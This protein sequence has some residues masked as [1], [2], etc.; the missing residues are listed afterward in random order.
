MMKKQLFSSRRLTLVELVVVLTI[1]V[2]LGGIALG[3]APDLLT[4]THVAASVTNVTEITKSLYLY[5]TLNNGKMPSGFDSLVDDGG[6]DIYLALPGIT[7]Y[8]V[9]TPT[10]IATTL[11]G[12]P[13][14]TG[15]DVAT[16]LVD[17][18]LAVVYPMDNTVVPDPLGTGDGNATF[19]VDYS[20][21][22]AV[23]DT[24]PLAVIDSTNIA[25]VF[26]RDTTGKVYVVLGIGSGCTLIGEASNGGLVEPPLHFGDTPTT[27]ANKSYT[28]YLAIYSIEND[29]G[30]A[31]VRYVGTCAPHE[32][33]LEANS[34]H[35]KEWYDAN[36][37]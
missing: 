36:A 37:D 7:E 6:T 29:D 1:L 20:T 10:D 32:S 25:R 28:R 31:V 5:S 8:T 18:G 16:A 17:Q 26:N 30:E 3:I 27:V 9:E 35:L 23:T 4:R 14:L 34:A 21:P 24:T 15:A 11:G 33:G 13:A 2:A 12:A 19:D 22:V